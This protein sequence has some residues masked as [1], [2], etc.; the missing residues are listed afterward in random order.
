M[1]TDPRT[2]PPEKLAGKL[3]QILEHETGTRLEGS[4]KLPSCGIAAGK[5]Q[6]PLQTFRPLPSSDD[7]GD[8]ALRLKGFGEKESTQ[9]G[10]FKDDDAMSHASKCSTCCQSPVSGAKDSK[11]VQPQE[12]YDSIRNGC[13][14]RSL[15]A[16]VTTDTAAVESQKKMIAPGFG[17][18][19][20]A[21]QPAAQQKEQLAPSAANEG[22]L[23]RLL[24]RKKRAEDLDESSIR[25][26][27]SDAWAPK[28]Q[29]QSHVVPDGPATPT[30]STV[31][32]TG[33]FV[34]IPTK[35]F[36]ALPSEFVL[37]VGDTSYKVSAK[38]L[39]QLAK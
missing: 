32:L 38:P 1:W 39:P 17:T 26:D 15:P 29:R 25:K 7:D 18:G 24:T 36:G 14:R 27:A 13:D 10:A 8:D 5:K 23:N 9:L 11:F 33:S 6:Q 19:I 16:A 12:S 21:A 3:Q 22:V 31:E 37:N 20:L 30:V 34:C 35:L 28:Q 4:S 2:A